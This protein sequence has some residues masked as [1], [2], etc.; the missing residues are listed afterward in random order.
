MKSIVNYVQVSYQGRAFIFC[1]QTYPSS[2]ERGTPRDLSSDSKIPSIVKN[3]IKYN[4]VLCE[5]RPISVLI[6]VIISSRR[7][8]YDRIGNLFY[9][10]II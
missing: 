3:F 9:F 10:Q 4:S 2:L 8:C 1:T 6:S 5:H 7:R